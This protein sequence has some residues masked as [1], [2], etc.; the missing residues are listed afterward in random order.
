MNLHVSLCF[1]PVGDGFKNRA[2]RF[3]ALVNCTVID[4][5]QPWPKAALRSV[6]KK[7]I[8]EIEMHD[9][10]VR[11]AIINFLPFSFESVAE[12]SAK[13][14]AAERR[15]VH[16]TPKSFLELLNLYG[17]TLAD[18]RRF[19]EQ[20]IDRLNNGLQKLRETSESV[21]ELEESLKVQLVEAEEKRVAAEALAEQVGKDKAIVEEKTA[22]ADVEAKNANEI[23]EKVSIQA[24]NCADDLAKAEPAVEEAMK[25][26]DTLNK[27]D[28]SECKTMLK[29]PAGVDGV[30]AATQVLLAG[31]HPNVVINKRGQVKDK[32]DA[33]EVPAINWK[34]VRPY[35][36]DETFTVEVMQ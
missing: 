5:F 36:A 17:K 13:F 14:L 28:L 33:G 16:T 23:S 10:N 24:K 34:E 3:P 2:A 9:E 30:F 25:A 31:V 6:G 11:E 1:S 27:K 12:V 20:A 29:P 22:I 19:F 35:L 7:H 4:W 15:H 32:A 18:K 26:L 8:D 21:A